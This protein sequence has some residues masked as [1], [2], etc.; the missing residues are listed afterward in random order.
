MWRAVHFA[1]ALLLPSDWD[2]KPEE[3]AIAAQCKIVKSFFVSDASKTVGL[4]R[5]FRLVF[6]LLAF[7]WP[8]LYIREIGGWAGYPIRKIAIDLYVVFKLTLPL[9]FLATD[10]D[11]TW[12]GVGVTILLLAETVSYLVGV[13]LFTDV[14]PPPYSKRRSYFLVLVNYFEITFDFAVLYRGVGEISKI[15]TAMDAV[16][17]S[18]VTSTTL[19]YGDIAP[20]QQIGRFLVVVHVSTIAVLVVAVIGAMASTL[21]QD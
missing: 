20:E 3:G 10:T 16:Y 21:R 17:F 13:F 8:A 6:A 12:L 9:V 15:T 18:T 4:E 14:Y 7:V 1:R 2:R 5:L 11:Q 19:G